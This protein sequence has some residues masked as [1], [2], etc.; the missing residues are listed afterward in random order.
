[1]AG[2]IA[3]YGGIVRDGLILN[4]DAAKRDSYPGSGTVWRDIVG[5]NN[6]TLT[7]GPTFDSGNGG[8]I[9][10]DGVDDYA[11]FNTD[12][13]FLTS[14]TVNIWLKPVNPSLTGAFIYFSGRASTTNGLALWIDNSQ[15]RSRLNGTLLTTSSILSGSNWINVTYKWDGSTAYLYLNGAQ[16]NTGSNFSETLSGKTN[17]SYGSENGSLPYNG[18]ISLTQIYNRALSAQEVLQNYNAT[19]SRFGL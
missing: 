15:L 2:R 5:A 7:N 4:L 16:Q 9:V 6:G 18:N 11:F 8:S 1:M 14:I 3:Y 10:F 12:L 13:R 17:F 19:K